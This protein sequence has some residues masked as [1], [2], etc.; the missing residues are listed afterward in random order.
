MIYTSY[1]ASKKFD[2]TQSISIARKTPKYINI[3]VYLDLAPPFELVN[4]YKNNH[5]QS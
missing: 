5:D 4:D 3:P 2:I 1:F